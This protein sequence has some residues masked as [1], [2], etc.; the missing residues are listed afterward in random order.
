MAKEGEA[1]GSNEITLKDI[2]EHLK[3]QDR[4]TERTIYFAGAA[5]G[6]SIVIG[7][8]FLWIT[9]LVPS[10]AAFLWNYFF[11]VIAGFGAMSW[12]WYKQRKIKD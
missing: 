4:Q 10:N 12:C 8:G 7:A 9:R 5:F 1:T 3:R 11:F 2:K 6:A